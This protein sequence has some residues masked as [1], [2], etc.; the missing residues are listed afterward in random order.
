MDGL[1]RR[2]LLVG[3]LQALLLALF[4]W[5]RESER[6]REVA[7]AGAEHLFHTQNIYKS[8]SYQCTIGVSGFQLDDK[9]YEILT[10]RGNHELRSEMPSR[11]T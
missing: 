10:K 3:M 8:G 4:P 9:W 2:D 7:K 1:S 5:L 11:L 6:G